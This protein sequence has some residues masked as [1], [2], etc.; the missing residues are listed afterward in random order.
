MTPS[1][2][3]GGAGSADS[4]TTP[5][6]LAAGGR[7]SVGSD[8]GTGVGAGL[9]GAAAEGYTSRTVDLADSPG[10]V[11]V[12][13]VAAAAWLV[14]RLSGGTTWSA[15]DRIHTEELLHE[16]YAAGELDDDDFERRLAYIR[17]N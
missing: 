15:D 12:A 2:G 4:P 14:W 17:R 5:S 10:L 1:A 3:P 13:V 6:K 8:M 9:G 16:R 11:P 7:G